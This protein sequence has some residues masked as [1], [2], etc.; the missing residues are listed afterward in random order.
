M[1]SL[2][3]GRKSDPRV[4]MKVDKEDQ[5]QTKRKSMMGRWTSSLSMKFGMKKADASASSI[6]HKETKL[7]EPEVVAI[8]LKEQEEAQN[9]MENEPKISD[10]PKEQVLSKDKVE[11]VTIA[12]FEES[13]GELASPQPMESPVKAVSMFTESILSAKHETQI[14]DSDDVEEQQAVEVDQEKSK[15]QSLQDS[16]SHLN[17]SELCLVGSSP[18]KSSIS[19]NKS[20][21]VVDEEKSE[22]QNLEEQEVNAGI[23]L[24]SSPKKAARPLPPACFNEGSE[25]P[26]KTS[27][28]KRYN[29]PQSRCTLLEADSPSKSPQRSIHAP[30]EV[31]EEA[32]VIESPK[33]PIRQ[34]RR[35]SSN[36]DAPIL[37]TSFN[38]NFSEITTSEPE[39]TQLTKEALA[40]PE[41]RGR[42]VVSMETTSES[43][44]ADTTATASVSLCDDGETSKVDIAALITEQF[45]ERVAR[46]LGADPWGDRQD[47][48]DAIQYTIKKTDLPNAPNKKEMLT[49]AFAAIQFGVDDRVAPVM[50]C[51]LECLRTVL[52]EFSPAIDRS[53][54]KH[55]PLIHQLSALIKSLIG[56]LGDSNKRTQREASQAIIRLGK[57]KR[58]KA[59]P[60]ILAHLDNNDVS[61]RFRVEILGQLVKEMGVD[62]KSEL[63]IETVMQHAVVA[64][65]VAEEKT[66]KA[67]VEVI[68]QLQMLNSSV[69]TK[70]LS[71]TKAEMLRV[72]NRRVEELI[73]EKQ[74]EEAEKA[75]ATTNQ[76]QSTNGDERE[77][78][79]EL[80]SIPSEDSK[81]IVK[82][83]SSQLEAAQNV[84]GPVVWR[85]LESKTW[86]D[87][88][89]AL[90]DI[91][92]MISD[93]KSD[94]K[95]VR[96]TQGSIVQ[97]NFLAYCI[98]I[99]KCLNDSIAPVV[100]S[101]MDCLTTLSKIHG[102][103]V[104]WR[105]ESVKDV[106]I[107]TIM[108]LFATMQKPNNRSNRSAC[109]CLLKLARLTNPH[110]FRYLLSCIFAKDTDLAVQMHLLRLLIPEFGFQS[111]GINAS[112][113]LTSVGT[114]LSHSNEKVRKIATDVALCTQR[115]I[116]KDF[117]LSKLKDVVK[118]VVL[119]ELE[120][121]FVET[122]I[123]TSPDRPST[124]HFGGVVPT[125]G[126]EALPPVNLG[127]PS[128][129]TRR[130]LS[131][132]PVGFGKLQCTPRG[133]D[134]TANDATFCTSPL[135]KRD[136]LLSNDE[137][138]LMSSI[139]GDDF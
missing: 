79:V 104:E 126:R 72:I 12:Q 4:E 55:K 105:E 22:E 18:F 21:G 96:P 115:L 17:S 29:I 56:K 62:G 65:K 136:S 98:V 85:K 14:I 75:A 135:K 92:K 138:N 54:N 59:V 124:V 11:D 51:S 71:G 128:E 63:S 47:G 52:K 3:G 127:P 69:V 112:R 120:K 125:V 39:E 34:I 43:N 6:S 76:Q 36:V 91:E 109:R 73:T 89:E 15:S 37:A 68:A 41:K 129:S 116:G 60:F 97:Q 84:I 40:S 99:H 123:S 137:E 46:L 90:V 121:H 58:I 57:M 88:K 119:K 7:Q 78:G 16:S 38:G 134:S 50:Y 87:R 86:S 108:R 2:L 24:P 132:A 117:V 20:G 64:L 26:K 95:E 32:Q 19:R 42:V 48:F 139:L 107:Q 8:D 27:P 100:N 80:L 118:P 5:K 31:Q 94:L 67:A 53:F 45:T 25:S 103:V 102:P 28:L 33:K 77:E 114:A 82:L 30:L 81:T 111:D 83:M 35:K 110:T 130:M 113:V 93:S 13:N 66:R 101:A 49:A 10:R 1:P 106:V 131:S 61:P 122:E 133:S 23:V 44:E 9:P 70:L 74:K